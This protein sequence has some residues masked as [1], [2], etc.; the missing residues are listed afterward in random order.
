MKFPV[1]FPDDKEALEWAGISFGKGETYRLYLSI[2]KLAEG[3]S[4]EVE[5]LRLFGKIYTRGKPYYVVEG[6]SPE[7]QEG[8]DE[9]KQEGKSG[10]NKYAYWVSQNIEGNEWIKLPN[11]TMAQITTARVTK[12]FLTGNLDAPV[13]TYPPFDGIEK[14][15]LRA[16]I[17]RIAAAT[18]ISPDGYFALSEDDPPLVVPAEAEAVNEAFPKMSSE[19]KDPEAWKHHETAL[20]KL[21][22]INA[23]PEVLGEDGEPVV[24]EEEIEVF[25]PLGSLRPECWTFR[26]GPGGAGVSSNSVVVARSLRWPGAVAIGYG[27]KFLNIYV[28][29]AV[30]Q[31]NVKRDAENPSVMKFTAYT[32][33]VPAP[34]QSE[35]TP[36]SEEEGGNPYIEQPDTKV[37]PT[38]P[39]PEGQ[40]EEE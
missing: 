11:V 15:L 13:R 18:S 8:I 19:L 25:P 31:D 2:K 4:S 9:T 37:D 10:A 12:K 14:N 33:M 16:Q 6:L 27:R 21:G 1:L 40:E 36:P 3:L 32:P 23:M 26:L 7:E 5:K 39:V 22:R 34:I 24:P 30:C 35:W 38:P 20:N 28:G 29:N 17:A